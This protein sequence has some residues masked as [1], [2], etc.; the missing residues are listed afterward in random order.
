MLRV[1]ESP[2]NQCKGLALLVL[3]C[4]RQV[5][6]G[7]DVAQL[8]DITQV[9]YGAVILCEC[10]SAAD[11]VGIGP[12]ATVDAEGDWVDCWVQ[13]SPIG[14]TAVHVRVAMTVTLG[15]CSVCVD[16]TSTRLGPCVHADLELLVHS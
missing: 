12:G 5:G 2:R 1:G 15:V 7:V 6:L 10:D 8:L 4:L 9:E 16:P 3:T 14:C 13:Q 11:D